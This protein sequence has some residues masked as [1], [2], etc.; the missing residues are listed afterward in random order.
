MEEVKGMTEHWS[1]AIG[2]LLAGR[3][4]ATEALRAFQVFEE[5]ATE[6]LGS[7]HPVIAQA[8][9]RRGWCEAWL[10]NHGKARTAYERTLDILSATVGTDHPA[11]R[12]VA[13]Y[14]AVAGATHDDD[15]DAGIAAPP[16]LL[17][18]LPTFDPLSAPDGTL[19]ADDQGQWTE[20]VA[21][22]GVADLWE[23]DGG[24]SA[25][26]FTAGQLL[27]E[28][29][30]AELA[31]RAFEDYRRWAAREYGPGH[32]YVLQVVHQ[33]AMCHAALGDRRQAERLYRQT[34]RLLAVSRPGHPFL[35][36]LAERI[37][38]CSPP[39]PPVLFYGLGSALAAQGRPAEAMGAFGAYA[40][41]AE[42]EYGLDHPYV[43]Q[44]HAARGSC[45]SRLGSALSA[46]E[47]MAGP[48]TEPLGGT[49]APPGMQALQP[50]LAAIGTL[51]AK[52][53]HYEEAL[54]A[55]RQAEECIAGELGPGDRSLVTVLASHAWCHEQLGY[56]GEARGLYQRAAL[57]A[58]QH[59]A[60]G[61]P[62]GAEVVDYLRERCG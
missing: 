47:L 52:D 23:Q 20:M 40:R 1:L 58:R 27:C 36:A 31:V 41:W 55:F 14:L 46:G 42:A 3:G 61:E 17:A 22:E 6:A 21:V 32:E 35:S 9:A 37:A 59:E 2:G 5:W 24:L 34:H 4:A 15:P 25:F 56:T 28:I 44:A 33:L 30:E 26:G 48:S 13:E 29:G 38:E 60:T 62:V 16:Y 51:L 54:S 53:A 45:R 39:A 49:W 10:G 18:G 50:Q 8:V 57:L 7:Q 43:R 19:A 11:A 12:A